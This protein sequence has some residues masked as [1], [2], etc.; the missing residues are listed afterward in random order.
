MDFEKNEGQRGKGREKEEGGATVDRFLAKRRVSVRL[1]NRNRLGPRE[2]R[3][4]F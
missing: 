4:A 2:G 1:G 3:V